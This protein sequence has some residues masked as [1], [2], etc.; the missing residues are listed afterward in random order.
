MITIEGL[1]EQVVYHNQ[2]TR[3]TVVRLKTGAAETPVTVVGFMAGAAAGQTLKLAGEWTDHPRYGEQFRFSTADVTLPAT[4]DGISQYL[5]SGIVR[6]IGP[7]TAGKILAA[8][9]AETLDILDNDPDRLME[10][11]GIGEAK[12]ES[13]AEQWRAH[14]VISEVMNLLQEHGIKA[15]YGAK[16]YSIYGDEALDVLRR[17]PY[18]LAEDIAGIGFFM[19]DRIAR[20]L[21]IAP[22]EPDRA[23]ACVGHILREAAAAGH[24]YLPIDEL[25]DRMAR[26]YE[27]LP[28]TAAEAV[29][30][31]EEKGEIVIE[32]APDDTLRA[33][34]SRPLHRAET[35]I[36][37]R[38]AAMLCIG[39]DP[40]QMGLDELTA[41][42]E[43]RFVIRLSDE[44]RQALGTVLSCR[45]AVITGGPGTGKTTL[46]KTIAAAFQRLGHRVCLTAPTGRAARR[47]SEVTLRPAHT[48]HKLLGFNF[49]EG[50]FEKGEDNPVDAD[51]LIV[52]EASMIDTELMDH[53]LR[54]VRINA[55]LIMVGDVFQ[56]PPVGPGNTLS[57][58]IAS[59]TVPVCRLTEIFRQAAM[60]PIVINAH[61]VREGEIPD[62]VPWITGDG[63]PAEFCFIEAA[64]PEAITTEILKLC[65]GVLRD[66]CGFSPISDIQVLSPVHKGVAGTIN[67]NARLQAALNP[68]GVSVSGI[69]HTFRTGDRVMHLRNNYQKEVFNGDTGI[70]TGIDPASRELTVDY[71][72]RE[73]P[74]S[75]DEIDELTLGY[76]ISVH[77]SQGSEYPAIVMPL[78]TQHY[79]MLQRNL[80]YT[81]ITRARRHVILVGTQKALSVALANDKP[82]RR[83]TGLTG[84]LRNCCGI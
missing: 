36:A 78:T 48:I 62:L 18:R 68:A 37:H 5:R 16:I 63:K 38:L 9:G 22:D 40:L 12:A 64:S 34:Y 81:A 71:Y 13:I 7:V 2:T 47:L 80:L 49:E 82:Q 46:V 15:A 39:V 8:F 50:T 57:D 58:L 24:V 55:R 52:D 79:V 66:A 61:R 35:G 6:G 19:A 65:T 32:E 23:E 72:G 1:V 76:A 25:T 17:N 33:V 69:H 77:K 3:Y 20:D 27:I 21:G 83:L 74:Y 56:L 11:E 31:V 84:R 44:Q 73:V 54:A 43:D 70:I 30:A 53:L 67:L 42:V 75:L 29:S 10:V 4:L 28:E 59:E 45:A 14:R 26:A 41:E 51:V 60:S